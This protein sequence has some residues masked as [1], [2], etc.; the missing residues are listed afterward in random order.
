MAVL[1]NSICQLCKSPYASL[2]DLV[3][4]VRAAHSVED[5]LQLVWQVDGCPRTFCKTSTWYRHILNVHRDGCYDK[6]SALTDAQ[7]AIL[8]SDYHDESDIELEVDTPVTLTPVPDSTM[9]LFDSVPTLLTQDTAA[10][11]LLK[12]KEKHRLTYAA[13][14]EVVQLIQVISDHIIMESLTA[15][16]KSAESHCLDMNSDFIHSLPPALRS[17][18]NPF[19]LVGTT[20]KQQA[21][22]AKNFPYVVS[23][24]TMCIL[25][26]YTYKPIYTC[27]QYYNRSLPG[28]KLELI[29]MA[30]L[31]EAPTNVPDGFYMYLSFSH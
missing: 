14:D 23:A 1:S 18:K 5:E 25:Y 27:T 7:H 29:G 9:V 13:V 4:H 30:Q 8:E 10:G 21:Y 15:V 19:Y 3:S 11:H 26:M 6:P 2:F 20:Y 28:L 12:L 17:T 22:V 24:Y 16:Q 31:N